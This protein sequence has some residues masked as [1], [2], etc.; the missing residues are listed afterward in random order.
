MKVLFSPCSQGIC[1]SIETLAILVK[2]EDGREE[3][4]EIVALVERS[5]D[6]VGAE[7]V[8]G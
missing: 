1:G 3:L 5:Q 2:V 8:V 7:E 4:P 6:V